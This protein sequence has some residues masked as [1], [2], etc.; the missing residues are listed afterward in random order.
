MRSSAALVAV[1]TSVT[2]CFGG[3]RRVT[4]R[5]LPTTLSPAQRV[6]AFHRYRENT[7]EWMV[8]RRCGQ[9][10]CSDSKVMLLGDRT[11][12]YVAED[13]LPLVDPQSET[14]R[15]ARRS[16][17]Q[18]SRANLWMGAG[19]LSLVAGLVVGTR[20]LGEGDIHDT[21]N[22]K[23]GGVIAGAGF[24][25][26]IAFVVHHAGNAEDAKNRAFRSYPRD[27]AARLRVCVQGIAVVPC[28]APLPPQPPSQPPP[29]ERD[30]ALDELRQQ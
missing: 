20:G 10:S 2:A 14:A 11:A 27:L 7:K 30:P 9:G 13:L 8:L 24:I 26:A 29:V 4:F 1:L 15:A 23:I 18:S 28:E 25:T 21:T 16:A 3:G 22:M 5:P 19:I 12:V 6:D 17:R